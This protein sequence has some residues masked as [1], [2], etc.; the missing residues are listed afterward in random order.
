[1]K[2]IIEQRK[3]EK[4]EERL[5]RQRVKDQIEADK[6]ARKAKFSGNPVPETAPSQPV[7]A[8]PVEKK[9]PQN[10]NEVKLQIRLIDGKY[11]VV[12]LYVN[13]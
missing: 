5:A 4:E 7:A 11:R 6:L 3:R 13:Y 1:M 12:R 9:P 2:K 10:Y 8:A